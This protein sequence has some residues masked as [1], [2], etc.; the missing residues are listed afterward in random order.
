[1]DEKILIDYVKKCAEEIPFLKEKYSFLLD[2]KFVWKDVPFLTAE[3]FSK[4]VEK[5]VP[6]SLDLNNTPSF[7]GSG[8]SKQVRRTYLTPKDI[9]RVAKDWEKLFNERHL[10][11]KGSA[12]LLTVPNEE[13]AS[14]FIAKYILSKVGFKVKTAKDIKE[15]VDIALEGIDAILTGVPIIR[16][17]IEEIEKKGKSIKDLKIR[18]LFIGGEDVSEYNYN[19]MKKIGAPI[20]LMYGLAEAIVPIAIEEKFKEGY[21]IYEGLNFVEIDPFPDNPK[22]GELMVTCLDREGTRLIKYKTADFVEKLSDNKIRILGRT[23]KSAVIGHMTFFLTGELE[24]ALL[25]LGIEDFRIDITHENGLDVLTF[26]TKKN[27]SR[28]DIIKTISKYDSE[29]EEQYNGKF[30]VIKHRFDRDL[31]TNIGIKHRR[32]NDLRKQ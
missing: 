12:I 27:I 10:L 31:K 30:F 28:E 15:H 24:N 16:M 26:I 1:M 14:A 18:K 23:D 11:K 6:P 32:I 13:Y 9:E 5:L 8:T 29:F 21:E 3:E 25:K 2:K 19:L 7:V 4:N 22:K 17:I 20:I